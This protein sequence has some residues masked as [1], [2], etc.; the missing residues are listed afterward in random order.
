[1]E[2]GER[3]RRFRERIESFEELLSFFEAPL[4][5]AEVRETDQRARPESG[6]TKAPEPDGFGQRDIGLVPA[7]GGGEEAAV[8]RATERRDG[9]KVTTRGDLFSD[10]DP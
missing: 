9:G 4:P 8:V 5:H 6:V 7:S 3:T 1:M 2:S 10:A